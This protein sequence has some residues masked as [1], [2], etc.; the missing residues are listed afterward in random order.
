MSI[1]LAGKSAPGKKEKW[2]SESNYLLYS[3]AVIFRNN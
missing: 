2:G 3:K 1:S